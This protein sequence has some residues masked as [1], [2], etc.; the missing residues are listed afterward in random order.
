LLITEREELLPAVLMAPLYWV[1]MSIASLRAAIQLVVDPF[2]WEK[3]TH[4]LAATDEAVVE[5]VRIVPPA[6][7]VPEVQPAEEVAARSSVD[8]A[9][10]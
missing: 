6:K 5:P 10:A 4:G 9:H 8:L 7:G 2:H 3:T 1:L